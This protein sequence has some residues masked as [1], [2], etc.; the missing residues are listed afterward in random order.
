MQRRGGTSLAQ[1]INGGSGTETRIDGIMM[2]PSWA[3]LVLDERVVKKLGLPGH[4]VLQVDITLDMACQRV[5]KVRRLEEPPERNMQPEEHH[6]L[7]LAFWSTVS[8]LWKVVVC[9]E[10]TNGIWNTWTWTA[11]EFLLLELNEDRT[12]AS[13]LQR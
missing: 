9:S 3:S 11:E 1:L 4:S 12:V 13:V 5:T 7:A 8:R 10:D 2:D 6:K